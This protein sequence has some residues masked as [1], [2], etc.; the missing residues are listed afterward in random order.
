MVPRHPTDCCSGIHCLIG[1][2]VNAQEKKKKIHQIA[3][4]ISFKLMSEKYIL[5][6]GVSI[7][8]ADASH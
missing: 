7:S 6:A 2:V 3:P 1:K 4:Q 8:K 5:K